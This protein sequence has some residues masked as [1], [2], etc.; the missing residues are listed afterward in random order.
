MQN[1]EFLLKGD[2]SSSSSGYVHLP[3]LKED[4]K[5]SGQELASNAYSTQA[6]LAFC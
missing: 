1:G 2:L 3:Q 5:C 6:M 4:K